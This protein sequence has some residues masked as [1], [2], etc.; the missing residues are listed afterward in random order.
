MQQLAANDAYELLASG[1]KSVFVQAAAPTG[2]TKDTGNNDAALRVVSGTGGGTGGADSISAPPTHT[3]TLTTGATEGGA[4][5]Y[6][7]LSATSTGATTGFSP[8]YVN[9]LVCTHT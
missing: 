8:K 9:I 7:N 1:T 3:H 5:A 2:W 4:E 6:F